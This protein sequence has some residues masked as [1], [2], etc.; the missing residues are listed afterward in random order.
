MPEGASEQGRNLVLRQTGCQCCFA[1]AAVI[2]QAGGFTKRKTWTYSKETTDIADKFKKGIA[3]KRKEEIKD[4]IAT[5]TES[6]SLNYRAI[7]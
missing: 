3:A 6:K 1:A 5:F 2:D 4:G 7:N